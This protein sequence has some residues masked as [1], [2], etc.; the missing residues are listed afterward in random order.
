MA[1]FTFQAIPASATTPSNLTVS[2]RVASGANTLA[3][4]NT[5]S[6]ASFYGSNII[7]VLFN[8]PT[9]TIVAGTTTFSA[10]GGAQFLLNNALNN[11]TVALL[12]A[13]GG[14]IKFTALSSGTTVSLSTL[15]TFAANRI[16]FDDS[17]PDLQRKYEL[18]YL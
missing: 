15:A 5:V 8:A 12:F 4:F 1:L 13:N 18:G 10:F 3:Q 6:G 16:A 2:S 17:W 11:Q 14:T 9:A 7:G